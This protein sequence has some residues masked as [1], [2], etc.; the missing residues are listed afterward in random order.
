MDR[1]Q[2]QQESPFLSPTVL[3]DEPLLSQDGPSSASTE[4]WLTAALVLTVSGRMSLP[5]APTC[6]RTAN[7]Q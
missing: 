7:T 6:P 1:F 5:C 4:P 3:F 2:P